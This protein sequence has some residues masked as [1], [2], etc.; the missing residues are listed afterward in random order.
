MSVHIIAADTT[1]KLIEVMI[2]SSTTG[3]GLTGVAFGSVTA[4]YIR[5]GANAN[6][7]I[8]TCA[9]ANL[10][11]YYNS[12]AAGTGGG[13]HEVDA[14]HQ[15]GLYQFSVPDA[16][17]ATAAGVTKVTISFSITGAIDHRSEVVLADKFRG[18]AGPTA[19]PGAA[20]EAAGG[21]YTRGTGAGQI[22][23]PA[24]GQ[25]DAN[26]VKLGGTSQTGRDVGLSV[27]LATD[28]AVNVTKWGGAVLPT[29]FN[30][31]ANQ[32]VIV[33][34]GT[35]TT[36]TNLPAIT[37]GWLTATGIAASALNGKGDWLLSSSYTSPT[38][39]AVNV[40]Q[41]GGSA[42]PTAF[43]VSDKTGFSLA[44]APPT[45][46]AIRQEMDAN[47]T[48]LANLDATVSSRATAASLSTAQGT[49]TKVETM[50]VLAGAVYRFTADSLSLSPAGGS[51]LTAQQTRDAMKLAP[52]AGEPAVGSVDYVLAALPQ[53]GDIDEQLSE[54]HGEGS[55]EGGSGT[56]GTGAVNTP[57]VIK[58]VDGAPMDGVEVTVTSDEAGEHAVAGPL[59]TDALGTVTVRLDAGTY[60]AWVQRSGYNFV[61]P[62]TVTVE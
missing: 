22:N 4:Y 43:A 59:Y 31:N 35:V 39:A 11:T 32:H 7:A 54:T 34:S 25:V 50:L 28:Q 36:L 14:T 18:V 26:A 2:R 45:A 46:V 19:L 24:N 12:G 3:Q 9:A 10:G 1:S 57:I 16:A 62:T 53:P 13:W 42:L 44:T 8:T 17:L 61:N 60:Y 41:W 47:S 29:A 48:K 55:W 23:Q 21:L 6:V 49:L 56:N 15:P 5:S 30:L 52:S 27:L 33:D 58:D 20:A 51:G 38:G 40:T 37:A